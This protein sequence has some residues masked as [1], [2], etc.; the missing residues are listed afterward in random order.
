[1]CVCVSAHESQAA[2]WRARTPAVT[3]RVGGGVKVGEGVRAGGAATVCIVSQ[4]L[5]RLYS[6]LLPRAAESQY[7]GPTHMHG[8]APYTNE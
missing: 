8:F 2:D 4:I 7:L 5:G 3:L 1:M 6:T